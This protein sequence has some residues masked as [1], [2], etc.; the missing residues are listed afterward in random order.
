MN[1]EHWCDVQG[2]ERRADV[3]IQAWR[4]YVAVSVTYDKNGEPEP[5]PYPYPD[6][7][8]DYY[9]RCLGHK[10]EK[11]AELDKHEITYE[12]HELETETRWSDAYERRDK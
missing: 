9:P 10:D 8:E 1:N 6:V 12:V 2:C 11:I 3:I 5:D 4:E 7:A